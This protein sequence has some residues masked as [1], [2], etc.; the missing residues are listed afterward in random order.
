[1]L[2][3]DFERQLVALDKK[4]LA[5]AQELNKIYDTILERNSAETSDG[6]MVT[7]F[8]FQWMICSF[9]LLDVSLVVEA[10]SVL[11]PVSCKELGSSKKITVTHNQ[12]ARLV[13]NLVIITGDVMTFAHAS[14]PEYLES[15]HQS[16]FVEKGCHARMARM[17][18]QFLVD[19]PGGI[20]SQHFQVTGTPARRRP[21]LPKSCSKSNWPSYALYYF[22]G[23]CAGAG[24]KLRQDQDINSLLIKWIVHRESPVTLPQW[25]SFEVLVVE[26]LVFIMSGPAR[27]LDIAEALLLSPKHR[28]CCLSPDAL[29]ESLDY[30]DDV[31]RGLPL[32]LK[33]LIERIFQVHPNNI[34]LVSQAFRSLLQSGHEQTIAHFLQVHLNPTRDTRLQEV[35]RNNF[36]DYSHYRHE[37]G[38]LIARLIEICM[39][40]FPDSEDLVALAIGAAAEAGDEQAVRRLLATGIYPTVDQYGATSPLIIAVR[41]HDLAI[42]KPLLEAGATHGHH[43]KHE[44]LQEC[45]DSIQMHDLKITPGW[46]NDI[47]FRRYNVDRPNS[48]NTIAIRELLISYM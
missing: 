10:L 44:V 15:R 34:D 43:Y 46:N 18:I 29:R 27:L 39:A 41:H 12:I 24:A 47:V 38:H 30:M 11:Q 5:N 7:T 32:L 13:Q 40:Y 25:L 3:S 31:A 2:S 1:V 17:C 23:H 22:M 28:E 4:P 45:L 8:I 14:V 16:D 19:P 42:T 21:A 26:E 6:R 33:L 20:L 35:L 48:P 37:D 36:R 9:R